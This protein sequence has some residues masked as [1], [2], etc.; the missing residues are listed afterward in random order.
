M[1]R[2]S[3]RYPVWLLCLG[4]VICTMFLSMLCFFY[5]PTLSGELTRH[6]LIALTIDDGP[7]PLYSSELLAVLRKYGV[8]ATFFVVGENVEKFPQLVQQEL[9]EGH[10]IGNHSYSH[11]R[12]TQLNDPQIKM[13]IIRA[14]G[15]IYKCIGKNVIWFR[16][17]YGACDLRVVRDAGNLGL[18]TVMWTSAVE[19]SR[20]KDPGQMARRVLNQAIP[21]GIILLHDGRVERNT[22]IA[23]LPAIIEGLQKQGYRFVTLS[24]LFGDLKVNSR[25]F[26]HESRIP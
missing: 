16:P 19:T 14:N 26:Q 25:I 24:E 5:P 11:G 6:K 22:T 4:A 15:I 21:G 13:E 18:H 23:A 7:D 2:N 1:A 3:T 17:P 20:T 10:E 9:A 12:L 8:K